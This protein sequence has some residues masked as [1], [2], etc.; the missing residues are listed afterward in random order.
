MDRDLP[1]RLQ[2]SGDR[3]S[4]YRRHANYGF[5]SRDIV[6]EGREYAA[7]HAPWRLCRSG[8]DRVRRKARQHE[9]DSARGRRRVSLARAFAMDCI[10]WRQVAEPD[11][12]HINTHS[13]RL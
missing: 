13:F 11:V 2:K 5:N 8:D 4:L 7:V 3:A 12:V 9:M 10:G 1:R 6:G